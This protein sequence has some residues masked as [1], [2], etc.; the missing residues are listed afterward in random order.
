MWSQLQRC[1][2]ATVSA[3]YLIGLL[4][5]PIV[6]AA[7]EA[8]AR[9]NETHVESESAGFHSVGHDEYLCQICRVV[10]LSGDRSNTSR[11]EFAESAHHRDAVPSVSAHRGSAAATPLIPRAPPTL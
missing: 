7:I 9:E 1:G 4:G 10:E 2:K 5:L 3:F 11:L 6:D 8:A